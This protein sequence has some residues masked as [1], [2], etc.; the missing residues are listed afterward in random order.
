MAETVVKSRRELTSLL[1]NELLARLGRMRIQAI[2]RRTNRAQGEH[3]AGKG[4]AS[5]EFADYR[6]YV[7]GDDM[8]FVDWNIFF[9]LHRP[10]V[11]LFRLEEVIARC[12]SGR[13]Q[14]FHAV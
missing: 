1:D 3:L 6:D 7:P 11:K 2:R 14:H 10:Y 9:R 8:R 5:T 12:D 13:W 4:G